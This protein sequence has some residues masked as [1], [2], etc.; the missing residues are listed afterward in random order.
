MV[1]KLLFI[2]EFCEL[3][4]KI[5]QILSTSDPLVTTVESGVSTAIASITLPPGK[6]ILNTIAGFSTNGNGIRTFNLNETQGSAGI[7]VSVPAVDYGVTRAS[8]STFVDISVETIYYLNAN[9]TSGSSLTVSGSR[10]DA[11]QVGI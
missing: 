1:N 4:Q 9:Q 5:G 11:I 6:W 3:N 8:F 10:I 7:M 2:N